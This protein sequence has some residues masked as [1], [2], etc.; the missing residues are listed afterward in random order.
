MNSIPSV[1][2]Y[3]CSQETS[4][5]GEEI[6]SGLEATPRTLSPKFFYDERGSEL[7]TE[8][9]RQPEYYLTRVETALL[10]A[11]V[12]EIASLVGEDVLLIE[13]G[14]GSSEKIR[15]LLESLR[16]GI[17][18]PLDISKD[19]LAQAA[20]QLGVDYPWLEVRATCV[21]FTSEFELP[22]T[23][24]K[25]RVGFFPGSSIGN[26]EPV[27]AAAFLSRI[28]KLVGSDGGLLLGVDQKKDPDI[29]NNAYN[30]REGVTA[31]FNLNILTH[32][33]RE[34]GGDFD[35]AAFAHEAHY[36]EEQGCI[37][38]FLVSQQQQNIR[39]GELSTSLAAGEKI[40]TENSYKY[41]VDQLLDMAY[42]AGFKRSKV[43]QDEQQ[44]FSLFYLHND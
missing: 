18:A 28:R 3:D 14:S 22:F 9:T 7:F 21:D 11:H 41:T 20:E 33:N 12:E 32:L 29:L 23:S 15:L 26:F 43:W 44:L 38:M 16:P 31:A 2:F 5:H 37:Q 34:Y 4:D 25:R 36:N 10:R 27:D 35:L 8:I 6:L 24:D 1:H 17:Y 42:Q 19:Y 40:H 39:V 13:Y 30:D